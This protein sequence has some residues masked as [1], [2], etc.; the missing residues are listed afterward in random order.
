[1]YAQQATLQPRR[2][3]FLLDL[4]AKER[5]EYYMDQYLKAVLRSWSRYPTYPLADGSIQACRQATSRE[6]S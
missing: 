2:K 6:P 3:D 1:M 5:E 4:A